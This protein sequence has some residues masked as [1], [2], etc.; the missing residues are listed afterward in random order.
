MRHWRHWK[1]RLVVTARHD[2]SPPPLRPQNPV[3][4]FPLEAIVK[5]VGNH[6]PFGL[7]NRNHRELT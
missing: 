3:D 7:S 1:V 4:I 6:K 2:N 5:K